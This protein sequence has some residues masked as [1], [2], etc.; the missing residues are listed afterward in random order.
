MFTCALRIVRHRAKSNAIRISRAISATFL[1]GCTLPCL[2]RTVRTTR[3]MA[4]ILKCFGDNPLSSPS[5][6]RCRCCKTSLSSNLSNTGKIHSGMDADEPD[7]AMSLRL[8]KRSVCECYVNS[9]VF[10]V[11]RLLGLFWGSG[12]RLKSWPFSA[13][14]Y[15]VF[16]TDPYWP[17]SA[18][19]HALFW[20]M[21][22]HSAFLASW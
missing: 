14:F 5:S 9:L 10:A 16:P 13:P 21:A 19:H 7:I 15:M 20:V 6:C 11:L 18:Q 3:P 2:S 22:W 1:H 12:P 17:G 8:Q 4:S